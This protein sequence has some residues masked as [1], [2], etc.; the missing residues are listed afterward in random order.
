M[1]GAEGPGRGDGHYFENDRPPARTNAELTSIAN[2][3]AHNLAAFCFDRHASFHQN[4]FTTS[5]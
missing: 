1:D 4:P 3:L 5:A 2:I